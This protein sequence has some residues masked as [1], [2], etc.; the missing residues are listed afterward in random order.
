MSAPLSPGENTLNAYASIPQ[1][2]MQAA[3]EMEESL[4][5]RLD[6]R[7]RSAPSDDSSSSPTSESA[8][9]R[10][11]KTGPRDR[12]LNDVLREET[13][14]DDD[15]PGLE[16][17]NGRPASPPSL[18]SNALPIFNDNALPSFG[19]PMSSFAPA[20]PKPAAPAPVALV[21]KELA[22]I[23]EADGF[24]MESFCS[25]YCGRSGLNIY[26]QDI[27]PSRDLM[28]DVYELQ[29]A[30]KAKMWERTKDYYT[31][32]LIAKPGD[33]EIMKAY[34]EKKKNKDYQG[35]YP[36]LSTRKGFFQGVFVE[37]VAATA[38]A[39][40]ALKEEKD[41]GSSSASFDID[42][43]CEKSGKAG[44]KKRD[45]KK[46]YKTLFGCRLPANTRALF[47][48]PP[49]VAGS[50]TMTKIGNMGRGG[51]YDPTELSKADNGFCLSDK[52]IAEEG[53]D[54]NGYNPYGKNFLRH[55]SD[56]VEKDIYKQVTQSSPNTLDLDMCMVFG[57]HALSF[58]CILSVQIWEHQNFAQTEKLFCINKATSQLA[59]ELEEEKKYKTVA[60]AERALAAQGRTFRNPAEKSAA[61]E[62]L[63]EMKRFTMQEAINAFISEDMEGKARLAA[64]RDKIFAEDKK[65]RSLVGPANEVDANLKRCPNVMWFKRSLFERVSGNDKEAAVREK[66]YN[67]HYNSLPDELKKEIED[68]NG[69]LDY[70]GMLVFRV[71]TEADWNAQKSWDE[72][73]YPV[74]ET[75][76]AERE[77]YKDKEM[78]MSAIF[79]VE[80]TENT[81]GKVGIL[82]NN[83]VA[84]VVFDAQPTFKREFGAQRKPHQGKPCFI[85]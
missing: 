47:M 14:E 11:R 48:T 54:V 73:P 9:K 15:Q 83:A 41:S 55:F 23:G 29:P 75:T 58:L 66:Y 39:A 10:L 60:D 69:K 16:D 76:W 51:K 36:S 34:A 77:T 46:G 31:K 65:R 81:Q 45:K 17:E 49:M 5:A 37:D 50:L 72:H 70:S 53:Y 13:Q 59:Q 21:K 27:I 33:P 4:D 71:K 57:A 85:R 40:A 67:G 43:E 42:A 24:T 28:V 1:E 80:L 18:A 6:G 25:N 56:V 82:S 30:E 74:I 79:Q 64:L 20:P 3:M 63:L 38:A 32:Q 22:S 8:F 68:A 35:R 2:D 62:Q 7:K 52:P 19:I 26:Y 61:L 84:V 44:G 78:V 12:T